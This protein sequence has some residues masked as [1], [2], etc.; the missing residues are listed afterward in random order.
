MAAD[1]ITQNDLYILVGA[2]ALGVLVG[3][4]FLFEVVLPFLGGLQMPF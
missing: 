1:N 3:T 4:M 2:G